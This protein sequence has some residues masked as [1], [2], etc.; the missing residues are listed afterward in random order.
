MPILGDKEVNYSVPWSLGEIGEKAAVK[1]LIQTL[2]DPNPDMRVLA[3]Y[4]L[5]KLH[6]T[7]ALP[8]IQQLTH[9]QERIR[10]DGLIAVSAA[11]RV[12]E[13]KLR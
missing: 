8:A 4:A 6:G 3:I 9:D 11:A 13:S 12:A 2:D 5:E 1:P 10:F 7:E